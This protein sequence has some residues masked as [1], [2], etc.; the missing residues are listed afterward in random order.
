MRN[1]KAAGKLCILLKGMLIAGFSVQIVLGLIW[2][3]LNFIEVQQFGQ[4]EGFLYP[5]LLRVFGKV[6]QLLYL[7]QLG[8]AGMAAY[9][10]VKPICSAGRIK[11][12]WCVMAFMSLPMAMQCH[13]ALL[14]Y[15][16]VSSLFLLEL[17]CLRCAM[18][19]ESGLDLKAM[20]GAG[21]CW[22]GLALLL[23][24]Y[25]W[26]G[27]LPPALTVAVRLKHL[28]R[29]LRKLLLCA[30]L[31]A[32]FSGIVAGIGSLTKT[33]ENS[34]R[35][36]WFAMASRMSWPT[37][38]QDSDRWSQDLREIA[39]EVCWETSC[40]PDN[41]DKVLKPVIEEAVGQAK[42]QE[43]YRQIALVAWNQRK[44]RI[45]RQIG[46][47]ALIHGAPQAVLQLQ[48]MGVG[49][50]SYS[51]RNYEIMLM[52][53]PRLTK[54]YVD[55]SCWW[56]FCSMGLAVLL[57]GAR[58]A[59]EGLRSFFRKSAFPIVTAVS[60]AA[61]VFFYT[62]Q[63]AGMADYKKTV[64]AAGMWSLMALWGIGKGCVEV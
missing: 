55:Y 4:P 28:C 25:R 56:F 3:F 47:D 2:M 31:I 62:M 11:Y 57:L 22:V 15:S 33:Q 45:V 8:L 1:S 23:S 32:A 36:F 34:D 7:L 17:G 27:L 5:L 54:H 41:M 42:A 38:W 26:L 51:G 35:T 59:A 46:G 53:S 44:F 14:P 29:S 37:I 16:F 13:L 64:A 48:L 20:A 52:N 24:E 49:Y 19:C 39:M 12:I 40:L 10:L 58:C 18:E 60:L 50:D 61:V 9:I 6:P 21:A 30:L 43:Y 63:G